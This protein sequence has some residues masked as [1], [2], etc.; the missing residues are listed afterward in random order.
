MQPIAVWLYRATGAG[1]A[2][3]LM[4]LL[5]PFSG[6]PVPRLPFVTSIV[7][8]LAAPEQDSAQPYA[9]IAGHV[10]STIAGFVAFW[11]LGAGP[12]ASAIGVAAATLLML[13]F[14]ALHPPAGIDGFLV[15]LYQLSPTWLLDPVLV[16][17]IMLAGFAW[18]WSRGEK[19][20]VRRLQYR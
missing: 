18:G 11:A 12:T 8:T 3:G 6:E 17:A 7:L 4:E 1:I 10:V 9:V 5:A 13:L 15:P 16:G 20:L 19:L 14:R 2:I